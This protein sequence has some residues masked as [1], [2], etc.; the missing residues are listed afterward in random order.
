MWM[1][2]FPTD[3]IPIIT[4]SFDFEQYISGNSGWFKFRD[5]NLELQ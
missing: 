3:K 2:A 5:K 4:I 1:I